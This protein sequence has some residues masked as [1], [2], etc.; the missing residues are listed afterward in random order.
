MPRR[1]LNLNNEQTLP[2]E[3]TTK[4]VVNFVPAVDNGT[5]WRTGA[6]AVRQAGDS[7]RRSGPSSHTSP[8]TPYAVPSEFHS[9]L[10]YTRNSVRSMRSAGPALRPGAAPPELTWRLRAASVR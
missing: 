10:L 2:R 6:G 9:D 3:Y 7:S 8:S 5:Q 1:L 4:R